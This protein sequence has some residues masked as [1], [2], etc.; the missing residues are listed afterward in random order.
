MAEGGGGI[1]VKFKENANVKAAMDD[2]EREI[3]ALQDLPEES[4]E[5]TTKLI[6]PRLP[7]IR[8]VLSGIEDR[9]R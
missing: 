9:V 8:V 5:I 3:D 7:V 1:T 6:E 2:V 4:E